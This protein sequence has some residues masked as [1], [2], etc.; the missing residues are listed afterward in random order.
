MYTDNVK[1]FARS[2][3]ELKN[4]GKLFEYLTKI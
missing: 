3:K 1:F 4:L 2:K